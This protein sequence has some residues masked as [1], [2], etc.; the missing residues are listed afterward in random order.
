MNREESIAE[1]YMKIN[2]KGGD[3]DSSTS[4]KASKLNV[5]DKLTWNIARAIN[6]R[7]DQ[8]GDP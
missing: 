4:S 5:H 6:N 3:D 1:A 7:S 8:A 2:G